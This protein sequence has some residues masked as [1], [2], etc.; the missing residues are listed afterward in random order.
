MFLETRKE[1]KSFFFF[2]LSYNETFLE[3]MHTKQA[4]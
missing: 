4:F 2:F 1:K 3:R